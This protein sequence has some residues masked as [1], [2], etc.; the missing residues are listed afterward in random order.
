MR[1]QLTVG[2][3]LVL[4]LAACGQSTTK[5]EKAVQT[6]GVESEWRLAIHGGAGVI[7]RDNLTPEREAEY[8]AALEEALEAG[9]EVLRQGGTSLDAVQA[10]IIPM[11]NNPL[12]NAGVGAV[13]TETGGHELDA[14]IMSGIDRNAGSV[15]GVT[16]VKNPIL[17]ARAVMDKSR[18]VMFA[19]L[20]ADAFA[21]A[22]GLDLVENNYFDT[23]GRR[24]S[25]ERVLETRE[26]TSADKAGTVGAV[27][28]DQFGNL[29]AATLNRWYDGKS[30]RPGRRLAPNWSRNLRSKRRMCCLSNRAWGILHPGRGC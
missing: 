25:L 12:F 26:R 22:Q 2:L 9:A 15:A 19:G 24:R 14:S 20:G 4:S 23:E 3:I 6:Q 5:P 8:R 16:R 28:I 18:H 29:A 27:A 21:E 30:D 7:T 17:A 10:A 11:E 13:F 1:T